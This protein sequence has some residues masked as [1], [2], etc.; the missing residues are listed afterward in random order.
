MLGTGKM[1]SVI[2][3]SLARHR[4]VQR[5]STFGIMIPIYESVLLPS[6]QTLK[7]SKRSASVTTSAFNTS[8]QVLISASPLQPCDRTLLIRGSELSA[9]RVL[10]RWA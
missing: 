4:Q 7:T 1:V 5:T 10:P 6:L 2:Y 8:R 9:L 3:Q